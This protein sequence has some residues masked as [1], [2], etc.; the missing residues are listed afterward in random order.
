MRQRNV[1]P[2]L[3]QHGFTLVEVMVAALVLM[4]GVL[5]TF[6]MIDGANKTTRENNARTSATALAREILEQARTL[7]YEKVSNATL[8]TE[9]RAKP[10]LGGTV[11]SSG[12]WTLNRKGLAITVTSSV[13]T[14]DDPL[15]GVGSPVAQNACAAGN[16]TGQPANQS[17]SNPDDFRRVT[18]TI[19]WKRGTKVNRIVQTSQINNPGGGLGPRI[20]SFPN[21]FGGAQVTSGTQIPLTAQSTSSQV[22]TWSADDGRPEGRGSL[23]GPNT[24]WSWNWPIGTVGTGTPRVD[25]VVDGAYTIN[26]QPFDDRGVPGELRAA[27]VLLNRRVPL[28]VSGLAGG[29]S[30]QGSGG[31]AAV[32]MDWQPNDERDV[33][34]YRVERTAP[35]AANVC[36]PTSGTTYITATSCMDVNPPGG[37]LSYRVMAMDRT[38]LASPTSTPRQGDIRTLSVSSS[39]GLRMQEPG[40]TVTTTNGK[41]QL[42][43]TPPSDSSGGTLVLFYRI[44]RDGVRYTRTPGNGSIFI[45]PTPTGASHTY[46][47]SAVHNPSYNESKLSDPTVWNA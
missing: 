47:V 18:L 41:P 9:L 46:R 3:D 5:G 24:S 13:C 38:D 10:D 27:N 35:T 43:I 40:L 32:E 44:Y 29:R 33:I 4:V 6:V 30:G 36:P 45:D 34:G 17:D 22:L 7:D 37:T 11:D 14:Y 26:A 31:T 21:P 20:T 1:P 16:T 39:V 28:Q 15:D 23:V 8:L 19:E 2:R 42:N 25:W 12:K